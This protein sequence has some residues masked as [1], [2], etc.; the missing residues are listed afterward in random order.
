M[1]HTELGLHEQPASLIILRN[2][3]VGSIPDTIVQHESHHQVHAIAGDTAIFDHDML[4][5]DPCAGDILHG[6]RG[7]GDPRLDGV[8]KTGW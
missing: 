6:F 5:L 4:F 3:S 1:A 7:A 8:L 2:M